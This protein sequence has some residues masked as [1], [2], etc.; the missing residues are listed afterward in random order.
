M[1]KLFICLSAIACLGAFLSIRGIV[2]KARWTEERRILSLQ[3]AKLNVFGLLLRGDCR[4]I[5]W[6][7]RQGNLLVKDWDTMAQPSRQHKVVILAQVV[8]ILEPK[9]CEG[10]VCWHFGYLTFPS[11]GEGCCRNRFH[12]HLMRSTLVKLSRAKSYLSLIGGFAC[13]SFLLFADYTPTH[14]IILPKFKC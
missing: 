14:F 13:R 3:R 10:W 8:T 11:L 7:L 2:N 5:V 1:C 4:A 12:S 9:N 6:K